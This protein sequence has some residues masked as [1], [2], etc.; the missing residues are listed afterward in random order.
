MYHLVIENWG[1][2]AWSI[3]L[4]FMFRVWGKTFYSKYPFSE[5]IKITIVLVICWEQLQLVDIWNLQIIIILLYL[6]L[7]PILCAIW[8]I[9]LPADCVWSLY[10]IRAVK[11]FGFWNLN[12]FDVMIITCLFSAGKILI[13]WN[14]LLLQGEEEKRRKGWT[15]K[16]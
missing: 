13:F 2:Y 1:G 6:P 8:S 4:V 9:M 10:L 12:L 5:K 15:T 11:V 7:I 14:N 3:Y 16:G